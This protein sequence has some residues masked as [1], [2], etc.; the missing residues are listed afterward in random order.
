[1][2]QAGE[3]STV[4]IAE[5]SGLWEGRTIDGA[6]PL[7][8][9]LGSGENSAVFLT[10]YQNRNA[11][12]KLLSIDPLKADAQL[13]RW[14]AAS[15]L[16]HP[17]L[18]AIFSTGRA[19]LDGLPLL[20]IVTE[21]AEE[22]LSQV[23]PHRALTAG[24]TREM[25]EPALSA[26]GYVHQ[27]GFVHARVKPSN[28][29]AV[30]DHL[31][32]SSDSLRRPEQSAAESAT[33][34]YDPPE[35][36]T[37]EISQAGDV[38]SL[39]MTL[40]EVLTQRLP[41]RL[42]P[43]VPEPFTEIARQC[44]QP[45][46]LDRWTIPRIARRLTQGESPALSSTPPRKKRFG[47]PVGV[48][49]LLALLIVVV[50]GVIIKHSETGVPP[51][52]TPVQAAKA[53]DPVAAKPVPATKPSAEVQEPQNPDQPLPDITEQARNTIHGRIKVSVKLEVDASG[54]VTDAEIEPPGP[55]RYLSERT[56]T[57]ARQWKFPPLKVDGRDVGQ[58]W[59]VRFEILRTGTKVQSK[60]L[61]P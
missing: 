45:E 40:V 27:Q 16:S 59:R 34:P 33:G 58:Q 12:I 56:L 42:P 29:M 54:A 50:L 3:N 9:F 26:L 21:Y 48:L 19:E 36:A 14:R 10:S 20:Y 55:S 7:R 25:L 6:F 43:E 38:W 49:I 39:G 2:Y 44:L 41:P 52:A 22:D 32:I 57:A 30:D 24:E 31:K 28:I 23:I 11:A 37:G 60:R 8:Q 5:F 17:N 4:R 13:A 51:A 15:R 18:A 47:L 35:R 46:A 53:P 1:M 61:A